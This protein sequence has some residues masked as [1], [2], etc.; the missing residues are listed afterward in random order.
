MDK[1]SNITLK[2]QKFNPLFS[3][4]EWNKIFKN[5]AESEKEFLKQLNEDIKNVH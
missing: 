1:Y 2:V 3:E 4:E 5:F